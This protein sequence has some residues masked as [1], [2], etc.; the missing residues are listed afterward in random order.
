M[1]Q[2]LV[3]I[4]WQKKSGFTSVLQRSSTK[5][6]LSSDDGNCRSLI[7]AWLWVSLERGNEEQSVK[8]MVPY[9]LCVGFTT[10]ETEF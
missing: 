1:E 8:L 9:G 5:V 3:F 10:D 2:G 6:S 4:L 7:E